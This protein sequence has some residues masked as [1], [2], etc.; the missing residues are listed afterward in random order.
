MDPFAL[1]DLF[2]GHVQRG[3]MIVGKAILDH[4]AKRGGVH[5]IFPLGGSGPRDTLG[6][7]PGSRRSLLIVDEHRAAKPE[8]LVPLQ[9]LTAVEDERHV[10][11]VPCTRRLG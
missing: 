3:A 7:A 5:Q 8:E 11:R 1:V 2:G 10:N 6:C 9:G 4:E